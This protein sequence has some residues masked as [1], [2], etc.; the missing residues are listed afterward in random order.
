MSCCLPFAVCRRGSHFSW[1]LDFALVC[2]SSVRRTILANLQ[3]N[4]I[5]ST[6]A[7]SGAK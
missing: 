1:L 6:G 7:A 4:L 3:Q 5:I 2:H